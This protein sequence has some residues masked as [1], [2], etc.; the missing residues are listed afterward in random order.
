MAMTLERSNGFRQRLQQGERLLGT[1][2]KTPHPAV[3]EVLALSPLD[4]L[5]LDAEHAPFGRSEL[6]VALLAARANDM[7]VLVRVPD[8]QPATILNALDL[9]ATGVVVPHVVSARQAEDIVCASRFGPGGRGYAG[10]TRAAAFGTGTLEQNLRRANESTTVI[11]QIE[12][13]AALP[14]IEAIAAVDG[15]DALFIGRMDLTLSLGLTSPAAS[16]V[17]EA[18]QLICTSCTKLRRTVGMFTQTVAEARQWATQGASLF[19]L[20]SDQQWLLQGSRNLRQ[21]FAGP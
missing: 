2:V 10:S 9:G 11:L 1:F 21:A 7:P 18:V 4:C 15:V 5:C 19:L 3:V 17:V 6:D 16:A 8:A 12:D 14:N 20:E 13:S